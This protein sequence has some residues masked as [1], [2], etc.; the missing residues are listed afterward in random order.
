M[1]IPKVLPAATQALA[2]P[3]SYLYF[4]ISGRATVPMVAAVATLD[5]DIA[6]K[7]AQAPTVDRPIPFTWLSFLVS[8]L[9]FGL[10]HDAWIAGTLAGM[11]YALAQQS[12]IKDGIN[13]V[14]LATDG[15]FN[16]GISNPSR[17]EELIAEKR[18]SG[19][20]L[21]VLGFGMGNL[22]NATLED[23]ADKGNGH[24]AY[25][26]D[27]AEA[28]KMLVEGLTGTRNAPTVVNSCRSTAS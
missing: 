12:F 5:P 19:V 6:A 20:Y 7:P 18:R 11:A 9:L 28:R 21:S 15:D 2:I 4:L 22:K 27:M 16:V 10:L 25:I 1:R 3:V 23:L 17:L 8:S 14:I 26:D 13:R 24:Y